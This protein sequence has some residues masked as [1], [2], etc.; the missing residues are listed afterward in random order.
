MHKKNMYY[1]IKETVDALKS[2]AVTSRKLV[3]SAIDT[4]E[5]D[6][7]SDKPLNAFLEIYDDVLELADEADKK[8]E[9]LKLEHQNLEK[10]LDRLPKKQRALL[11][12]IEQYLSALK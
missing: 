10:K 4:F 1:T 3:Q 5:S 7:K 11:K 12:K 8:I 9:K 2:G 6:K